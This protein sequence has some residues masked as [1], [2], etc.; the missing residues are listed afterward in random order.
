MQFLSPEQIPKSTS[1]HVVTTTTCASAIRIS[2]NIALGAVHI[3]QL[4]EVVAV[5]ELVDEI[6][7]AASL[8]AD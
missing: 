8:A 2:H 1:T 3:T 5:I 7:H 4:S 6:I